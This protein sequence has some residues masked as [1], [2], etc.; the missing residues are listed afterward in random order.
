MSL[1]LFNEFFRSGRGLDDTLTLL[2]MK[3][4]AL[5]LI[6][7]RHSVFISNSAQC[8]TGFYYHFV[9]RNSREIF[10]YQLYDRR[11]CAAV[12]D[13]PQGLQCQTRCGM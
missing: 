3:I 13:R 4:P 9:W 11:L 6:Q 2:P 5:Q 8:V 1:S 10:L 12:S 7:N